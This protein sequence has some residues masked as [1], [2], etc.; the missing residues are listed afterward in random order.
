MHAGSNFKVYDIVVDTQGSQSSDFYYV[1]WTDGAADLS[2][3]Q[4]WST[5]QGFLMASDSTDSDLTCLSLS[6]D[7]DSNS[8]AS[9]TSDASVVWTAVAAPLAWTSDATLSAL[10]TNS[11][12]TIKAQ[13]GFTIMSD[14]QYWCTR[15]STGSM[16]FVSPSEL[17]SVPDYTAGA[18]ANDHYL[19]D[20]ALSDSSCNSIEFTLSMSCQWTQMDASV[21][22]ITSAD[23]SAPSLQ[24]ETLAPYRYYLRR[25]TT[26]NQF[27]GDYACTLTVTQANVSSSILTTTIAFAMRIVDTCSSMTMTA[28]ASPSLS[29]YISY[30]STT[31]TYFNVS[32]FNVS[33]SYCEAAYVTYDAQF[34]NASAV[35]SSQTYAVYFNDTS[36]NDFYVWTHSNDHETYLANGD[37]TYCR[38]TITAT[39]ADGWTRF[40][41]VY[42][43]IHP[44]CSVETVTK[45]AGT[46]ADQTYTIYAPEIALTYTN[47]NNW[48]T[49]RESCAITY[50][51]TVY[52]DATYSSGSS[53]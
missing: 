26:D 46:F 44:D 45:P 36:R 28:P 29:Y 21:V 15:A 1:G 48:T 2:V 10:A 53:I 20:V 42:L 12:N 4:S 9:W 14:R 41:Y 17:T 16:T 37:Q 22:T 52:R 3:S 47:W 38:L 27:S 24:R 34:Q 32:D 19:S 39:H 23:T 7:F 49:S 5:K 25:N 50:T 43:I 51:V 18:A 33:D 30:S 35:D 13:S 11:L 6:E 8:R 40:M 31:F